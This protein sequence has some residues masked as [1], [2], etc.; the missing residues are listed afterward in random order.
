MLESLSSSFSLLDLPSP[1]QGHRGFGKGSCPPIKNVRYHVGFS[2]DIEC[3]DMSVVGSSDFDSG[4]LVP[5]THMGKLRIA[6]LP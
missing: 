4:K 6:W 5:P 2:R 1:K 3:P